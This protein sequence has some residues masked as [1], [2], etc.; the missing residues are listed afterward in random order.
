MALLANRGTR[1]AGTSFLDRFSLRPIEVSIQVLYSSKS[2]HT[3]STKSA[4]WPLALSDP[5]RA[6]SF[7][8]AH[9]IDGGIV[10]HVLEATFVAISAGYTDSRMLVIIDDRFSELLAWCGHRCLKEVTK[11]TFADH[12]RWLSVFLVST[13][14]NCRTD[15]SQI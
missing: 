5:H 3:T 6:L 10:K 12:K 1:K 7:D 15:S 8:V 13:W 2:T 11:M 9:C 4:F 14:R